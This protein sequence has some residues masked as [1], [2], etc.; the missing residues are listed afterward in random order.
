MSEFS[1]MPWETQTGTGDGQFSYTQEQASQFFRDFHN[2]NVATSGV[3]SGI[4][5]ELA[6]SGSVSP[7]SVATGKGYS[8]ARYWNDAV[9]N[10]VVTTPGV[11]DTGF[12]VVLRTTWATNQTRLTV[13]RS[14]DGNNAIPAL[15]F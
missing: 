7:L 13:L 4:D 15:C 14:A 3:L 2:S 9:V 12:R 8:Y 10:L 11:G 5:N 6:V 1:M